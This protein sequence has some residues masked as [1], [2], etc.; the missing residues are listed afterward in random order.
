MM[1]VGSQR[2]DD[3]DRPGGHLPKASPS[4]RTALSRGKPHWV[5]LSER[6]VLVTGGGPGGDRTRDPG[7]MSR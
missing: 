5:G 4:T 2:P 7:I 3:G 1:T 6:K